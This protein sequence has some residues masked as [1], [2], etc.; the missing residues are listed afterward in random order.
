LLPNSKQR[1]ARGNF[2]CGPIQSSRP[3]YSL[4]IERRV[5]LPKKERA[6]ATP[7]PFPS[8]PPGTLPPGTSP[9]TLSP[10]VPTPAALLRPPPPL[11]SL[12]PLVPFPLAANF[13]HDPNPRF[14]PSSVAGG[15]EAARMVQRRPADER[16]EGFSDGHLPSPVPSGGLPSPVPRDNLQFICTDHKFY[17]NFC[18]LEVNKC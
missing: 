12:S 1:P 6:L 18:R 7:A 3:P 4:G 13:S 16:R 9:P 5:A 11:P 14:F 10:S 15:R 8:S 17:F 2:S